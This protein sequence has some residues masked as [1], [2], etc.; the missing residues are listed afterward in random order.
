MSYQKLYVLDRASFLLDAQLLSSLTSGTFTGSSSSV[1]GTQSWNM[2]AT[3]KAVITIE[4]EQIL[5]SGLSISGGTITCTIDTRGYN[6]T[7]AA[8]HAAGSLIEI[9]LTKAHYDQLQDYLAALDDGG[10]IVQSAVTTVVS[11]TS[12]TISGDKTT[13]FTVGRVYL[14][15]VASTWYRALITAVSYGAPN[16][17]ITLLGD[18]LPASG[19]VTNAGFEFNQSVNKA[20]DIELIKQVTT[21]PS[22]NPPAGYLFL[23]TKNGGW[24]TRDSSGNVRYMNKVTAAVSSSGGVLTLDCSTANF[25]ECTLTENI[26]GVTWQNGTDGETYTLRIKQ[27][28]SAAKTV[29][30]GTSGG[31]RYSNSISGYTASTD[32][33]SSDYLEFFYNS[34]V[35]KWDIVR[36]ILGAQ[37]SPSASSFLDYARLFGDGSDGAVTLDGTV[38]VG[39]ASKV[40]SV[41]T[42]T[43][44]IYCTTLVINTGVTLDTAGFRVYCATSLT[45]TGTLR[46]VGGTGGSGS[47]ASGGIAG[48]TTGG[49]TAGGGAGAVGANAPSAA[50]GNATNITDGMG[51][52]GG[53]GGGSGSAGG[54]T[55]ATVTAT[56]M[57]LKSAVQFETMFNVGNAVVLKGGAGGGGGGSGNGGAVNSGGG[58]GGGGGGVLWASAQTLTISG[59]GLAHADGGQGGNGAGASNDGGGGGGGGGQVCFRCR[60]YTNSGTVR[61]NGGAGGA[62]HSGGGTGTV[63]SNN[64]S[65][66]ITLIIP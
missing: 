7:T 26:T 17:T 53:G 59:G 42:M 16:T 58:G 6:G 48:V 21:A 47:G 18:G 19:T 30:L 63:G 60:N 66:P 56:G 25:F 15:K 45:V 13:I 23:W 62:G 35:S 29:V 11:A 3:H 51:A 14:F 39:W 28:A 50:G 9:H 10:Y 54:G 4:Q 31:T 2:P 44:D 46:R 22:V 40:S 12:H 24:Y 32:L 57:L 41:Y 34:D 20:V 33:S 36:V 43:R 65:V 8:T 49:S 5:L 52:A 64:A 37:T 38:T 27:H 61:A 1:L 55:G